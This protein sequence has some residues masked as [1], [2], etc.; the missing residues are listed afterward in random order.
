MN[1]EPTMMTSSMTSSLMNKKSPQ[2]CGDF[3]ATILLYF[4]SSISIN[5]IILIVT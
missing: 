4:L 2:I 1:L 5:V 3:F